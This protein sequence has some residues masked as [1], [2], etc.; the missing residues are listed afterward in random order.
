MTTYKTTTDTLASLI[1]P[2]FIA[3]MIIVTAVTGYKSI[4]QM[5]GGP[6]VIL[7]FLAPALLAVML[8]AF[9]LYRPEAIELTDEALVIKRK[10]STISI[11]YA[12]IVQ[13]ALP[14]NKDLRL[15]VRTFGNGGL[16]GYTGKY[17]KQTYGSMTWYCSQR[18][19]YV[20]LETTGGKKIVVTPDERDAMVKELREHVPAIS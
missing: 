11:P 13:I 14:D 8:I 1:I 3:V 9:W 5:E 7:A 15:A 20:L 10:I 19:N 17:Y 6:A 4:E 16:F 12:D 2:G 18:K